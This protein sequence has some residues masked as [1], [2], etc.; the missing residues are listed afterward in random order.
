MVTKG[1]DGRWYKNCPSCGEAQNYLRKNYAEESLKLNK[2]CKKCSNQKTDN[3]HR[4]L[5]KDIRLS[6]FE[7]FKLGADLRGLV[8]N[9]TVEYLW[10]LYEKQDYRCSLTGWPIGWA[11]V[12][13]KHTCSIDRIDSSA[14]YTMGNVQLVHKDVNMAKQQYSQD[15]FIELCKAVAQS[16]QG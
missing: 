6:W 2:D 12:G 16:Q 13:S 9:L 7:K 4:G 5:Y 14:G 8:F 1:L 3:C 11:K 15:Y 10:D